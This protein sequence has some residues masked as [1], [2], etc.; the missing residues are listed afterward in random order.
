MPDADRFLI[1]V[2]YDDAA[3]V[4]DKQ[5]NRNRRDHLVERIVGFRPQ[6]Q[7]NQ[8]CH[9][10]P[11]DVAVTAYGRFPQEYGLDCQGLAERFQSAFE[12][13]RRDLQRQLAVS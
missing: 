2:F 5:F 13:C 10:F 4:G 11:A 1:V 12:F 8:A 3:A 9:G 7:G 6:R